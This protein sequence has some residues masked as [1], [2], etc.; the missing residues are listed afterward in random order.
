[1]TNRINKA[2]ELLEQDQPVYY[3]GPHSGHVLT[4]EQ[5]LADAQT[6][7]D[8]INVGMEHGSFD[9]TGLDNYL[10]GLVDGG[11]TKSGHKTPAIIVELPVEGTS[12]DK[13]TPL[14][15]QERTRLE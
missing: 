2:M 4:Y 7:A 11:P 12:E 1:M 8:Y 13:Y 5:G 9:M 10:K 6:W 3:M 15:E 14:G